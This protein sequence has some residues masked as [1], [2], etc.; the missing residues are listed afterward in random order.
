M[1]RSPSCQYLDPNRCKLKLTSQYMFR[2]EVKLAKIPDK[3]LAI[4]MPRARPDTTM[5]RE[6]ARRCAG[7]RSPTRGSMSCGVTVLRRRQSVSTC[8]S[9]WPLEQSVRLMIVNTYPT[10]HTKLNPIKVLKLLVR[11]KPSHCILHQPR[12]VLPFGSNI[13]YHSRRRPDQCQDERSSA[14]FV[15]KRAHKQQTGCIASL[16][17]R[18]NIGRGLEADVEVASQDIQDLCSGSAIP[19]LFMKTA[20]NLRFMFSYPIIADKIMSTYR[21]R[22]VK[23]GDGKSPGLYFDSVPLSSYTG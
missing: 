22:I 3:T 2:Q 10:P 21:L 14:Y 11:H 6:L 18:C 15:S 23:I 12:V 8:R 4:S 17:Q 5:E 16:G 7:A 20:N 1:P 9:S 19:C 13:A